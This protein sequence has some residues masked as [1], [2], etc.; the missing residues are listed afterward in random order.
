ML[1]LEKIFCATDLRPNNDEALSYALALAKAYE[2][3]VYVCN[4]LPAGQVT[5]T[6]RAQVRAQIT[7]AVQRHCYHTNE[8]RLGL[9]DWEPLITL[10][11]AAETITRAAAEHHADLIVMHSRRQSYA[12]TLLGSTAEAVSRTAPCPVLITHPDERE[13]V[14]SATGAIRLKNI[15]MAYD[16]S[17]DSEVALMF[18][19][20]L[21]EEYQSELHLLHVLPSQPTTSF[22]EAEDEEFTEAA[23]QL[24]EA[25][26][27][28]ARLWCKLKTVVRA[29]KPYRE[30]LEYAEEH[31]VDLICMGVRGA[32]FGMQALFGSN[33]D[34]VLRQSPCPILLARPLKPA[35]F[36]LAEAKIEAEAA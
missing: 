28:E 4:A 26:P 16:F 3:K 7:T 18:A 19:L 23:R 2:A 15:L 9:P 24:Q 31:E 8:G 5:E 30:V 25:I 12:A 22:A 29:G 1:T 34:R 33:V 10:G 14:D 11:D 35:S 32:G 17:N 20:M 6:T 13:W 21:A 36:V 27:E